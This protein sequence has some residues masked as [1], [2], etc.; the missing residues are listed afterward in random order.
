MCNKI[1]TSLLDEYRPKISAQLDILNQ[2][3]V[4]EG[5]GS[6]MENWKSEIL[7]NRLSISLCHVSFRANLKFN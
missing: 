1:R 2:G 4:I 7:G 3:M 5:L 6:L